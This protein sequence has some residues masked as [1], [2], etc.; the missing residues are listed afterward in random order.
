MA[1]ADLRADAAAARARQLGP[2]H[3][4]FGCDVAA[5]EEVI[6]LLA[7]VRADFGQLDAVV[8]NAG[9]GSPHIPTIEQNLAQFEQVLRVHLSGAFLVSREAFKLMA[10][11]GGAI[12]N[13]SSIAGLGGLPSAQR[14]WR[15]RKRASLR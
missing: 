9:I 2:D 4:G 3:L 5:E 14:L 12:V 10:E 8:N 6:R 7:S 11:R 15:G 1:L 13:I